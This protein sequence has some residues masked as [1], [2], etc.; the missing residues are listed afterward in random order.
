[1]TLVAV[2]FALIKMFE[3]AVF[4]FEG[5]A[6]TDRAGVANQSQYTPG[7]FRCAA[8]VMRTLPKASCPAGDRR[9]VFSDVGKVNLVDQRTIAEDPVGGGCDFPSGVLAI[10]EGQ[11]ST[12]QCA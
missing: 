6:A 3:N 2:F 8:V 12:Q 5:D 11:A 1:M 10:H 7:C 4:D 9:D